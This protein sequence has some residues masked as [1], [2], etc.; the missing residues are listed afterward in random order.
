MSN[1]AKQFRHM[2]SAAALRE[3]A[4]EPDV[5]Q[6][7]RTSLLQLANWNVWESARLRK[8][9]GEREMQEAA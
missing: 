9:M 3:L 5:T 8:L 7:Q 6:K 1:I 2:N 4:L